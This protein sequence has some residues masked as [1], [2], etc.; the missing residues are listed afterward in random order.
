[1]KK[2][3]PLLL[4]IFIGCSSPEPQNF[5]QLVLRD[6]LYYLKDSNEIFS[7]PVFNIDGKSE[8][9]IKKGKFNGLYNSYYD[10]GQL[11]EE[12]IFKNGLLSK[13]SKVYH[14]N[15]QIFQE[16][17]FEKFSES[18]LFMYY[19]SGQL[20]TSFSFSSLPNVFEKKLNTTDISNLPLSSSVSYYEDEDEYENLKKL[21]TLQK[22]LDYTLSI[23]N[24][25]SFFSESG[26]LILETEKELFSNL[27]EVWDEFVDLLGV[28]RLNFSDFDDDFLWFYRGKIVYIDSNCC[29][30]SNVT[31]EVY[32][33]TILNDKLHMNGRRHGP[34]I[35]FLDDGDSIINY[36]LN[37][38]K[39][40]NYSHFFSGGQRQEFEPINDNKRKIVIYF[41]NGDT[42]EGIEINNKIDGEDSWVWDGTVTYTWKNG[43]TKKTEYENGKLIDS[44]EY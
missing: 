13:N 17:I 1:M 16:Y 2:L 6:G 23:N 31:E 27:P 41:P 3:L 14:P 32:F 40:S 33:T 37:D 36:Y 12:L 43:G 34:Y 4:L 25:I 11:K 30:Y 9:Y 15:G 38:K 22:I 35:M 18:S 39:Q 10:N 20:L 8:G 5:Q 28:T 7:G 29:S 44:K 19:P 21:R 24:E 42:R 26:D